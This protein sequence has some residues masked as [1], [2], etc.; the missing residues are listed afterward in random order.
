MSLPAVTGLALAFPARLL[1]GAPGHWLRGAPTAEQRIHFA[2][3]ESHFVRC[4]AR[5]VSSAR[6]GGH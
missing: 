2:N 1:T 4:P 6:P 5:S 3:L